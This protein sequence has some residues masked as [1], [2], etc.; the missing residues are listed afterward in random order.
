MKACFWAALIVAGCALFGAEAVERPRIIAHRG[1]RAEFDDNAAGGFRRSLARGITGYETDVRATKDGALVIMHDD[2]VT[3]TT[4]GTGKVSGMTCAAFKALRLKASGEPPPALA[5]LVK[6]FGD[7]PG[8]RVEFEMKS[9]APL[10]AAA[11][12]DALY[13]EASG[14]MAKGTYVFTSFNGELVK[15]M[16]DRH[17]EAETMLIVGRVLDERAIAD[18]KAFGAAGVAA[19]LAQGGGKQTTKEMVARAHAEGLLVAVWMV[20]DAAAYRLARAVGA[21]TCTSDHPI[22]LLETVRASDAQAAAAARGLPAG[23]KTYLWPEGKMPDAQGHQIAATVAETRAPGFDA[24]RNRAPHLQW[25]PAPNPQKKTGACVIV[26]SG[27]SYCV[28]CDIPAFEPLVKKLL[29]AGVACVNLTYRTP[30]PKGLPIYQSA[31]E[32]GQRAVRLVRSLAKARGYDP[33][34]IGVMGC[35]AGSHLAVM[36]GTSALTPAYAP[37]DDLDKL[38]CHVNWAIPMCPAYALTDGL[39]DANAQQ[40]E[41]PDVKLNPSFRFDAKTCPMCFFHGGKDPYSPLGSTQIY[42]QLRRMRIPAELHLDADRGHGPV[43]AAKFERALEFMRQMGYLGP[44]GRAQSETHRWHPDGTRRTEKEMLWPEGKMPSRQANP[45]YAPYLVW[46]IP[47]KPVT[48]AIQVI[49]AGGGYEFCNYVGEAEPVAYYLNQKGMT[50]VSVKYRCPRPQ[51][52]PKHLTA[53][54]DAQRAIRM[55]RAEAPARGLDPNRIGLMGF[56]AGGH[57]T[58]MTATNAKTPAYAPVD[59]V[60]EQPCTLQWACPIYPAYALTDGADRPNT[61]GGN[62]DSAVL[63][64]EF[65]FDEATPPMCFVHGDADGWA[66]MNSV[67]AWEKLRRMGRQSDLHTLATRGHCFQMSAAPGTGS[68]TWLD[69]LWEFYTRKGFNK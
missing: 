37:V 11:Y 13:A 36:L 10:S 25:Y 41:G 63:V 24:A 22:A 2:D 16:R 39:T 50:A 35:S 59:A 51:N 26:L 21:D 45:P 9:H 40:G 23:E 46:Y 42:R 69:R 65:A 31:W 61:T 18:A 8:L 17:P 49:V 33:E 48:K 60:D 5:D 30:R 54:Q 19:L 7:R 58:L 3:R 34:K 4:T 29:D 62:D 38:P 27:G 68:F 14:T 1:G 32:D 55:V 67:K 28:C 53:W 64:P 43:D 20:Q 12:C 56:S 15:T 66:A 52:G 6:V 47:E 44:L 57:L